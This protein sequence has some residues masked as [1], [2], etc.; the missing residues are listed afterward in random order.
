MREPNRPLIPFL[1]YRPGV[2]LCHR[3]YGHH[4]NLIGTSST[5][6]GSYSNLDA[7]GHL[8]LTITGTEYNQIPATSRLVKSN[9]RL[10]GSLAEDSL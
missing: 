3:Y 4:K 7:N 10:S 1:Y 5:A 9:S 6:M 2:F 8:R